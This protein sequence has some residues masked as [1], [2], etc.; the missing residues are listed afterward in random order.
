MKKYLKLIKMLESKIQKKIIDKLKKD[1]FFI[2]KIIRANISGIPD[3]LAIKNGKVFF[4]E[5]KTDNGKL[6]E[7]QKHRIQQ[8]KENGIEVFIWKDYEI[9]F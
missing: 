8:I 3:I 9:N 4:I 7:I 2:I 6:S 1:G 5:V